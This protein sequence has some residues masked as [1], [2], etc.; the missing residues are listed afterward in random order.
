MI[1]DIETEKIFVSKTQS[2]TS[3]TGRKIDLKKV[4]ERAKRKQREE[5]IRSTLYSFVVE[6]QLFFNDEDAGESV[7]L[8]YPIESPTDSS[9]KIVINNRSYYF[10]DI[11]LLLSSENKEGIGEGDYDYRVNHF[12]IITQDD[13]TPNILD[14]IFKEKKLPTSIELLPTD[15]I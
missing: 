7:E 13:L 15:Y 3:K 14:K 2:P 11:P 1:Q 6:N 8:K 4:V 12:L 9:S 10:D 5:F